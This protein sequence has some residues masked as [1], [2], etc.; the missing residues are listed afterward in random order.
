MTLNLVRDL[1]NPKYPES[2]GGAMRYVV[3]TKDLEGSDLDQ[4]GVINFYQFDFTLQNIMNILVR[5]SKFSQYCIL[6]P[7]LYDLI[8][9]MPSNLCGYRLNI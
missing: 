5:S 3:C 1:V 6:W 4:E 7:L 9:M 8:V 2:I